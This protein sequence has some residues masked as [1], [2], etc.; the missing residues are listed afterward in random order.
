M[1]GFDFPPA[2]DANTNIGSLTVRFD[3]LRQTFAESLIGE[4][5]HEH[6]S[7]IGTPRPRPR[8]PN[9]HPTPPPSLPMPRPRR[10]NTASRRHSRGSN[11]R[12]SPSLTLPSSAHQTRT[13]PR[14]GSL[15]TSPATG[16]RR[17]LRHSRQDMQT[18]TALLREEIRQGRERLDRVD[19]HLAGVETTL[20]LSRTTDSSTDADSRLL[21]TSAD[22]LAAHRR[23]S[24]RRKLEHDTNLG[25][26]ACKYGYE[27]QVVPGLL[28]MEIVGCDGG[29]Y[30][31]TSSISY[32]AENLL[33][34][35]KS[36]Y[37]TRSPRCNLMLRHQGESLFHL[38][39]IVIKTPELD[40]TAPLQQGLVF[41]GMS[42]E[43]LS[44]GTSTYHIQYDPLQRTRSSSPSD[45]S[46]DREDLPLIEAL[47]DP[48]I[49]DASTRA[50]S[51]NVPPFSS[52]RPRRYSNNRSRTPRTRPT[53]SNLRAML[54]NNNDGASSA[55]QS[56]LL[57]NCDWPSSNEAG[58]ELQ[59]APS[60]PP[61]TVTWESDDDGD[62]DSISH[63]SRRDPSSSDEDAEESAARL[64]YLDGLTGRRPARRNSPGRIEM[65]SANEEVLQPHARFFIGKNRNKITIKFD[66]PVSGRF[67]LLKLFSPELHNGQNIDI[68]YVAAHGYA[69]PRFFPAVEMK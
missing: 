51:D 17:S 38:D 49:W 58:F 55:A 52:L 39:S 44:T 53:F 68:Q 31:H 2:S 43:T 36:V 5:H 12:S 57:D 48:I 26:P 69:G 62:A 47:H 45:S 10:R 64:Y 54:V 56:T 60:P 21:T 3:G 18:N 7:E 34:D 46:R 14:G 67:L 24:K 1:S 30:L 29:E 50:R 63:P 33:R 23:L 37:C 66:P 65:R 4:D 22:L 27:G 59:A 35:D 25:F 13:R 28:K 11:S 40:Y 32:K 9:S 19:T 61:F 20:G 8:Q 42:S 16:E 6:D 15:G 41:I